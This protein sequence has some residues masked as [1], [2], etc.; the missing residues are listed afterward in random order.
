M[1]TSPSTSTNSVPS[2]D[3][4]STASGCTFERA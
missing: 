4:R 3:W 2:C 1:S